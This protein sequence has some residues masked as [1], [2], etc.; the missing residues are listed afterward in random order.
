MSERTL[1]KERFIIF[2]FVFGNHN[3]VNSENTLSKIEHA[4]STAHEFHLS[5][6]L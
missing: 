3:G 4:P 6:S 2:H 1:E 5:I